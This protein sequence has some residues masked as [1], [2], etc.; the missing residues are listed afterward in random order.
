M[1]KAGSKNGTGIPGR[2]DRVRLAVTDGP[3]G[4]HERR[5]GLAADC[6]GG[7]VVHLDHLGRNDVLEAMGLEASGPEDDRADRRCR[8]SDGAGNDLIRRTVAPEG[9]HGDPETHGLGCGGP[10]GL[11]RATLVRLARRARVMRACRRAAVRADVDA[12]SSYAVLGAPL[13]ATGLRR[14]SLGD[15]HGRPRSLP[16]T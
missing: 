3:H 6:V 1:E 16:K 12:R 2:Y 8:G 11:N 10:E 7:F 5:V 4:T 13:V 15:S 9:V 14:L